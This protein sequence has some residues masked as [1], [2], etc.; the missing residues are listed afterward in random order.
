MSASHDDRQRVDLPISRG[1]RL[2]PG[3]TA[4]ELL[5]MHE[6]LIASGGGDPKWLGFEELRRRLDAAER[7]S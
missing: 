1:A 3:E 5:A 4:Q 7:D 2:A 6:R